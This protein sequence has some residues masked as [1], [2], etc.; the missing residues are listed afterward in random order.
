MVDKPSSLPSPLVLTGVGEWAAVPV[1]DPY[2]PSSP[3]AWLPA[4]VPDSS[5]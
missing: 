1:L 4:P 2:L 3:P 5:R